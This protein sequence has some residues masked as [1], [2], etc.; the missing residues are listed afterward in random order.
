MKI[1]KFSSTFSTCHA[2]N[3]DCHTF[4]FSMQVLYGML[5]LVFN[6]LPSQMS[7]LTVTHIQYN[8]LNYLSDI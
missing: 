6:C 8:I 5:L 4:Y 7:F 2:L 1:E 3:Y